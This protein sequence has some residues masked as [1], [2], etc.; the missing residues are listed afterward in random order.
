MRNSTPPSP[1]EFGLTAS[2]LAE[3]KKIEAVA[4]NNEAGVAWIENLCPKKDG[5]LVE[6]I[7]GL[8]F[9]MVLWPF[10]L[11]G[12]LFTPVIQGIARLRLHAHPKYKNFR[13]YE[14]AVFQ[15]EKSKRDFWLRLTGTSFERELAD[16]YRR[17]GYS[18]T[19][20]RGGGDKGVDIVLTGSGKMIIVQCKQH[21]KPVGPA[22]AR[23][24]YGTLIASGADSAIL[25]CTS[26]FTTGV[27]EFVRDKPIELLDVEAIVRMQETVIVE[28]RHSQR[29]G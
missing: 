5:Y 2:D 10:F 12:L 1:D 22:V 15:H 6:L 24:L 17:L 27:L 8:V 23:E 19:V 25:A 13:A 4:N 29:R 16:L 20:T 3:L 11:I 21:S 7:C 18:A 14:H 26:G 9:W 28:Q